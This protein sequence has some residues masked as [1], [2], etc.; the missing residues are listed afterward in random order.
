[1]TSFIADPNALNS[2]VTDTVHHAKQQLTTLII[3]HT[4]ITIALV[5]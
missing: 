2:H 1:M 3:P 5:V 4:K